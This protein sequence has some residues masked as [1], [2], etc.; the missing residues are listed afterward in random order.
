MQRA[1]LEGLSVGFHTRLSHDPHD[2]VA[3]A[4]AGTAHGL[5]RSRMASLLLLIDAG[6][7]LGVPVS[8]VRLKREQTGQSTSDEHRTRSRRLPSSCSL[9]RHPCLA[10]AF[11]HALATCEIDRMV[12]GGL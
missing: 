5:R 8:I 1:A 2:D 6:L 11:V 4:L 12:A 10:Q 9:L 7:R 3:V